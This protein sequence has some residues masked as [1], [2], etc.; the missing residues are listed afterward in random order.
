M[1]GAGLKM[2]INPLD[3]V[4]VAY[5]RQ[6][7]EYELVAHY[8]VESITAISDELVVEFFY[9]SIS[10]QVDYEFYS[11]AYEE[12]LTGFFGVAIEQIT[13][14]Q[15]L[16]HVIAV[17]L[18]EGF[19]LSPV[20]IEGYIQEYEDEI[21]AGFDLEVEDIVEIDELDIVAFALGSGLELG[22]DLTE[23]VS[24]EYYSEVFAE[25]IVSNYRLAEVY[26]FSYEQAFQFGL[27]EGVEVGL[28]TS[29]VVN[30]EWYRVE[31][32]TEIASDLEAIDANGDGDIDDSELYDY[33]TGIGLEAGQNPS[34]L[35]DFES[36]ISRYG[37]Q[38]LAYV[39][40]EL[41]QE[42]DSIEDV[43]YST[44]LEYM[45]SVGLEAGLA[46]SD[47]VTNLQEFR[48]EEENVVALTEFY[49]VTSIEE[50]TLVQ[51]FNYIY[52]AGLELEN[53]MTG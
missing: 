23:F 1:F 38:V 29:A 46:P 20:D 41:G 19:D 4:E 44:I 31:F 52:G 2:G 51:T 3:F 53:Q 9:G 26:N 48:A 17:G 33:I 15:I 11:F 6:A 32:A 18:S 27:S 28:N 8:E 34:E 37:D 35:I 7:F 39:Q 47:N 12:E 14:L 22:L 5:L 13:E 45:L 36:Y 40:E 43:S 49:G 10:E 25:Q 42:V 21:A 50:V 16:E 24:T 30:L